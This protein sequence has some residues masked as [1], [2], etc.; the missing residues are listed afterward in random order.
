MC[1]PDPVFLPGSLARLFL[2]NYITII[3]PLF[4]ILDVDVLKASILETYS[5]ARLPSSS[6]QINESRLDRARNMLVL[7]FGAQ[8][9]AGDGDHD[10]PRDV[11]RVWSEVLQQHALEIMKGQSAYAGGADIIKLWIVYAAYSRS[12][13]KSGGKFEG[14][15]I[16]YTRASLSTSS[17]FHITGSMLPPPPLRLRPQ[18]NSRPCLPRLG[19]SLEWASIEAVCMTS[20]RITP[21]TIACYS[22]SRFTSRNGLAYAM[23]HPRP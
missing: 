5:L 20:L 14:S 13:G 8:V 18:T 6:R 17:Y 21:M 1:I 16:A 2:N 10:C 3:H 19:N 23:V 9:I 7:A 11:A 12:Y 15:S 22:S 4:P